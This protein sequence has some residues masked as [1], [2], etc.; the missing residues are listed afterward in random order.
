MRRKNLYLFEVDVY[1]TG[2]SLLEG[3]I[4]NLQL[5]KNLTPTQAVLA[6]QYNQ[7]QNLNG[8]PVAFVSLRFVRDVGLN[9]VLDAF[10]TTFSG[11][12]AEDIAEFRH[13]LGQAVGP[14]GVKK[15]DEVIF[16]WLH[17]GGM[18]ILLNGIVGGQV[19]NCLVEERLIETYVDEKRT[20]S[21]QLVQSLR[22]N[23]LKIPIVITESRREGVGK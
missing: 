20:V 1:Q 5:N 21:P 8:Q 15:D 10:Q 19:K 3:T 14:H 16:A 17:E 4:S 13:Q 9:S 12:P 2:L 23:I 18:K 11:L 22:E 7:Q 6:S